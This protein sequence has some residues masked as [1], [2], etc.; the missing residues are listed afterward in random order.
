MIV[1]L[2]GDIIHSRHIRDSS[3]WLTPLKNL[4]NRFG[5]SPEIWE[6]YRGDSFQLETAPEEALKTA[7]LIKTTIRQIHKLDVRIAIGFGERSTPDRHI[8]E[9]SGDAFLKSGELLER[10]KREKVHL[11]VSSPVKHFDRELNMM[12]RLALII[13]NS[14]SANTAEVAYLF[15]SDPSLTQKEAGRKLGIAQSSVSERMKRGS[16]HEILALET[17]FRERVNRLVADHA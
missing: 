1:I 13:L 15:L 4:L 9:S 6:I 10:L 11:A 2:T 8:S 16:V 5:S 3:D 17:Y 12:L 7:L 14:W